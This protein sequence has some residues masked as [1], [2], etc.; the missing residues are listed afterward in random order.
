MGMELLLL[1]GLYLLF[2]ALL[3]Y[4]SLFPRTGRLSV[5]R[6]PSGGWQW[7]YVYG[8]RR[9]GKDNTTPFCSPVSSGISFCHY[10]ISHSIDSS[11]LFVKYDLI[12]RVHFLNR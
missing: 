9:E 1:D 10:N 6:M 7:L 2:S 12:M 8:R 3:P 4:A 5:G 11:L